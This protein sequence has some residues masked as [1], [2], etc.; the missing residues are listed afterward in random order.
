MS[1]L[2]LKAAQAQSPPLASCGLFAPVSA[3]APSAQQ[4]K[5]QQRA[6]LRLEGPPRRGRPSRRPC[7]RHAALFAWRGSISPPRAKHSA[8]AGGQRVGGAPPRWQP[9]LASATA[10]TDLT[11]FSERGFDAKA[12]VNAACEGCAATLCILPR[13]PDSVLLLPHR[14]AAPARS[15]WSGTCRSWKSSCSSS[16]ARFAGCTTSGP[17]ALLAGRRDSRHTTTPRLRRGR[18][19]GAGGAQRRGPEAPASCGG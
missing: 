8:W 7:A 5:Q 11:A 10:M 15:P 6:Q 17:V 9:R 3:A 1:T 19:S 12:W 14:S 13:H 4:Q 18:V 16:Q 2:N